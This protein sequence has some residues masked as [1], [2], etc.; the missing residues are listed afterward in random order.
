MESVVVVP[1][2]MPMWAREPRRL[3]GIARRRVDAAMGEARAR[4]IPWLLMTGG[5]VYPEGTPFVEAE[6][7]AGHA[8]RAGWPVDRIAIEGAARHTET[9]LRNA[10]RLMLERGWPCARIV[11]DPGQWSY[12]G[13]PD[14]FGFRARTHRALGH[15]PWRLERRS[16]GRLRFWPDVRVRR[17]GPDPLDP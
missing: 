16:L 12:L 8:A 5:A 10:G 9:N 1:G 2:F 7:M 15:W 17:P 14:A 13:Y 11:T 6:E 3:H 4:G